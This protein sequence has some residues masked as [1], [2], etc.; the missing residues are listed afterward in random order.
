MGEKKKLKGEIKF[1]TFTEQLSKNLLFQIFQEVGE[2]YQ[3]NRALWVQVSEFKKPQEFSEIRG[4]NNQIFFQK[5][6][7]TCG[8]DE[9]Y[10]PFVFLFL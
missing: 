8:L 4:K 10:F 3:N 2:S 5:R 1:Y 9:N 7:I 6:I